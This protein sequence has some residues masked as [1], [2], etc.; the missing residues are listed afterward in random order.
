MALT[1]ALVA[2]RSQF[3]PKPLGQVV[4]FV[5]GG[6]PSTNRP[7][8]WEGA[9][10]WVS[11]K[12]MKKWNITDAEQHISDEAVR[13]SAAKLADPGAVLVVVRGMILARSFPVG[14]ARVALTINQ[15]MKAL[16]PRDSLVPEFLALSLA[17]AE[18]ELLEKVETAA[19]GTRRLRTEVLTSLP[20]PV[21]PLDEQRRIVGYLDGV[22]TKAEQLRRLQ[23]ETQAEMEALLPSVLDRAFRGEL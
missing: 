21:P 22:R 6:T 1:A 2:S 9:I 5:G 10:P 7:A 11:P 3:V 15:D 4:R 16:C 20:M 19:H 13:N 23:E 8:Y 12:D 14:I 17:G 18:Q